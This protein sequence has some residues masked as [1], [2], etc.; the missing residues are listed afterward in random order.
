[1]PHHSGL[2]LPSPP[3]L[4]HQHLKHQ[5]SSGSQAQGWR[6][7][8]K[9]TLGH[10]PLIKSPNTKGVASSPSPEPSFKLP[11]NFEALKGKR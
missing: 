9:P 4:P 2:S 3:D 5:R 10:N 7:N 1:M 11:L 6:S 8:A